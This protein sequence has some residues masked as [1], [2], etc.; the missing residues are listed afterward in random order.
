MPGDV[1]ISICSAGAHHGHLQW[2]TLTEGTVEMANSGALDPDDI[3]ALSRLIVGLG[4]DRVVLDAWA[5]ATFLDG[6]RSISVKLGPTR[7]RYAVARALTLAVQAGVTNDDDLRTVLYG[8]TLC[9]DVL[10]PAIPVGKAIASLTIEEADRAAH[11][12]QHL[13]TPDLA[14]SF[15]EAGK[16]VFTGTAYDGLHAA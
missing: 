3:A 7:W 10:M 16:P 9:D 2:G 6:G 14:L 12:A 5:S 15:D 13:G 8:A 1:L 11:I 4:D